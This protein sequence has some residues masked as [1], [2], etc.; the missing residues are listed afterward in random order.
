LDINEW[1]RFTNSTVYYPTFE[2]LR[3]YR[4]TSDFA[5]LIPI[6]D[7]E[8]WKLKF[9]ALFE[10]DP[11]PNPGFEELDQTYYAAVVMDLK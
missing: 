5:L 2:E 4:L 7:S 1:L 3:D 11:I 10:Y 6:A 9:G 8:V